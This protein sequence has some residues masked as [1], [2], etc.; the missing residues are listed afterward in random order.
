MVAAPRASARGQAAEDYRPGASLAS[1][2]V[3]RKT[4][5]PQD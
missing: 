5:G 2:A 3:V 4:R 1:G